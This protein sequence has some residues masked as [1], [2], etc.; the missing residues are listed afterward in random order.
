MRKIIIGIL[1]IAIVAGAFYGAQKMSGNKKTFETVEKSRVPAVFTEEVK[2]S[3]SSLKII[4]SGK[5]VAKNRLNLFSEV[6]G[7]FETGGKEFKPGVYYKKRELLMKINSDEHFAVLQA[8]KSTLYNQVISIMPD[9]R[10][11]YPE[12]FPQWDSYVKEFDL[13]A[14]VKPLPDPVN[15]R[16]KLFVSGRNLYT[17]YY[18]VQNLQRRLEKYQIYAP[19]SGVITEALVQPGTLVRPGQALGEFID[20]SVYE[21][22]AAVNIEFMDILRVGKT[23]VL[24]NTRHT[25][26]YSGKVIRINGKVDQRTQTITVFIQVSDK[27]LKE[28]MYLE[29]ILDGKEEEETYEISR[30]VLLDNNQ[31]FIV[32]ENILHVTQVVPV[33]YKERTVIVRGLEDGTQIVSRAVPGAY[34]GMSVRVIDADQTQNDN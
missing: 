15:E 2:N 33:H 10:L 25:Q 22:E 23:V 20:Q 32:R 26:S 13:E 8:Q 24:Q 9:L 7:I 6:Q 5:L 34:V 31:V 17:T 29:A 18:N 27:Q 14:S 28:G 12:S 11:D 1:A 16:E 4:T 19:Y 21:L 3:S 30:K